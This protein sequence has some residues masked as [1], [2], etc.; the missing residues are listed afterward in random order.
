MKRL[1]AIAI[2]VATLPVYAAEEPVDALDPVTVPAK[3]EK[4]YNQYVLVRTAYVGPQ[5]D[6]PGWGTVT[7]RFMRGN[8]ISAAEG[9]EVSPSDSLKSVTLD[10]VQAGTES[11]VFRAAFKNWQ[12]VLRQ[13]GLKVALDE[14]IKEALEEDPEADVSALQTRLATVRTKLQIPEP[15][16]E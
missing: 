15:E 16:P 12:T 9:Y 6:S 7:A 13:Y 14:R 4:T 8:L 2:L 11:P 3:A 10:V 5:V 1:L